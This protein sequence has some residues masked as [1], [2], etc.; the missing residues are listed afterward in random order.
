MELCILL[1]FAL[2]LV[3]SFFN[4]L[5]CEAINLSGF[6][7]GKKFGP[8]TQLDKEYIKMK[9]EKDGEE[10]MSRESITEDGD[11]NV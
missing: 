6:F 5:V 11:F 3:Y 1:F 2:F 9:K 4:Y 8:H 7:L 10:I